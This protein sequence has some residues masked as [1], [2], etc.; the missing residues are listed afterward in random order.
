MISICA[1][2]D[3]DAGPSETIEID[4]DDEFEA[5]T[6]KKPK[7]VNLKAQKEPRQAAKRSCNR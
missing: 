2:A 5:P 1:T 7:A 3:E 4:D 6:P